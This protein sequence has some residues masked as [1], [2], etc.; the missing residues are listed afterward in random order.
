MKI[1]LTTKI[2]QQIHYIHKHFKKMIWNIKL[3]ILYTF[4]IVVRNFEN[5]IFDQSKNC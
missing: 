5:I 4:F 1:D 3:L 2:L